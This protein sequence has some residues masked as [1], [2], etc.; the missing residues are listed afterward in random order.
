MLLIAAA[1][2]GGARYPVALVVRAT[3]QARAALH[4]HEGPGYLGLSAPPGEASTT[5]VGKQAIAAY[6]AFGSLYFQRDAHIELALDLVSVT[7]SVELDP[8][9]QWHVVVRHE[10]ELRD[11]QEVVL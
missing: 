11:A 6:E 3:P 8:A 10:L 2:T 9:G 1:S 4:T 5:F 7:S